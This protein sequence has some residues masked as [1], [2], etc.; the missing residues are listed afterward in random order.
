M[1]PETLSLMK[2]GSGKMF[3]R[4]W[5][6]S[7]SLLSDIPAGTS[8]RLITGSTGSVLRISDHRGKLTLYISSQVQYNNRH[9]QIFRPELAW[10]GTETNQFGTDEF[11][12]WCKVLG[13]EPYLCFNFGTGTLD[14]GILS[15][16][17]I[18]S[19]LTFPQHWLGSSTAMELATH[20]TPIFVGRMVT[21]SHTMYLFHPPPPEPY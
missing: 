3:S 9:L 16:P 10:L 7:T 1:T 19:P 15:I 21:K 11:M 2:M 20:T 4:R 18:W 8:A 6:S 12:K 13:T 5:R 17:T 14:E